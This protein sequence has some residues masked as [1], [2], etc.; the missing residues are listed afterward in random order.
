MSNTTKD[1]VWINN[2]PKLIIAALTIICV[3]LLLIVHAVDA[4]AGLPVLSGVGV[5]IMT[6]GVRGTRDER[7]ERAH[8]EDEG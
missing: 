6:N 2:L 8:H 3:S 1:P 4:A 7:E 5:Y